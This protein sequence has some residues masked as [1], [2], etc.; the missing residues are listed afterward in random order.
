ML[1]DLDE[2]PLPISAEERRAY[3]SSFDG[4]CLSSDALIP[5]RDN[6]DRASRS[7]VGYV[8]QTGGS[9]RDGD[10]T[11]AADEYDMVMAHTGLRLFLH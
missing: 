8:A 9:T 11:E 5:F 6:I 10:V 3:L 7:N 4:V 2:R 1:A